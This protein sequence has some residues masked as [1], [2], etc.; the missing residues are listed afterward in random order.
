MQPYTLCLNYRYDLPG[1]RLLEAIK[2]TAKSSL[3]MVGTT[4][5]ASAAIVTFL[6]DSSTISFHL[7]S[8]HHLSVRTSN[9]R[10]SEASAHLPSA[11]RPQRYPATPRKA[12]RTE[13]GSEALPAGA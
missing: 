8:A 10:S 2:A 12:L 6:E 1:R 13:Q 9:M 5:E 4:L 3:S 7:A 11:R